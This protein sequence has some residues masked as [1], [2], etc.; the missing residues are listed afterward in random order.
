LV[1]EDQMNFAFSFPFLHNLNHVSVSHSTFYPLL[2]FGLGLTLALALAL[3]LTL[4]TGVGLSTI[5]NSYR[6]AHNKR[7]SPAT[8]PPSLVFGLGIR[9]GQSL[10]MSQILYIYIII[11]IILPLNGLEIGG[12]KRKGRSDNELFNI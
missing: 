3:T 10:S 1:C 2:V 11:N 5:S 9:T 7:L 12:L 8:Q 4:L 6:T